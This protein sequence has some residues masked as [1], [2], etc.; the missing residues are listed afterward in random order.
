[1]HLQVN[2][3]KRAQTGWKLMEDNFVT[4]LYEMLKSNINCF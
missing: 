3:I 2:A 1:M 4:I